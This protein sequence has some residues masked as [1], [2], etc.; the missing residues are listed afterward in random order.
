MEK[1][2]D[3]FIT[4]KYGENVLNPVKSIFKKAPEIITSVYYTLGLNTTKHSSINFD[5]RSIYTRH[6]SGR[7]MDNPSIS[8]NHD[9]NKEFHY[10]IDIVN[11]LAPAKYK[12]GDERNIEE[13]PEV[14]ENKWLEPKELMNE[15]YLSY[16]ITE[17][18]YG[19]RLS[20]EVLEKLNKIKDE[21]KTEVAF[22]D[23][24]GTFERTM[25]SSELFKG[26]AKVYYSYRIYQRGESFRTLTVIKNIVEGM[27][28]IKTA[29][30][31][32]K[33]YDKDYPI[34]QYDWKKDADL[35]LEFY[36]K[37]SGGDFKKYLSLK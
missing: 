20:H 1:V 6:V 15:K 28:E 2:Y 10:W 37:L 3:E 24:Y 13:I 16:I 26:M 30:E 23:L 25:L 12:K 8:I 32:I 27:N 11:H 33:N 34:G 22:N 9:V 17:K 14:L 19:R 29:A 5:Y 18:E 31:N 7:W 36:N 21:F 35:A 4:E